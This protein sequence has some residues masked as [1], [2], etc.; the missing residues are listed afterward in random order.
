[1]FQKHVMEEMIG[2]MVK[3]AVKEAMKGTPAS[4]ARPAWNLQSLTGAKIPST[5]KK[6]ASGSSKSFQLGQTSDTVL[7]SLVSSKLQI[8]L[9]YLRL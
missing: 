2:R 8:K 1:M 7:P 9:S 5:S 4:N 6:S 3:D